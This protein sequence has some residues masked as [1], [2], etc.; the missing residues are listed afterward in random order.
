MIKNERQ[1]RIT[2]AQADQ[3]RR[4]IGEITASTQSDKVESILRKA[5]L[6]G[7]RSQ[8][9]DLEREINEY[10]RLR[11]GRV[12][13]VKVDSFE[14]VPS[15]LVRARIS[16]GLTQEQLAERL[17]L[18][19]QQIQRYE[20][21]E[22]QSASLARLSEIA[23][24]LSVRVR[25]DILSPE[26][27]SSVAAL[28][29]RLAEIGLQKEFVMRRLLPPGT[30]VGGAEDLKATQVPVEA[31]EAVRRVYGWSPATLLGGEP[32]RISQRAMAQG[33]FKLPAR[34]RKGGMAAYLVYAH[35]LALLVL[36]CTSDL[37][38]K[39]LPTDPEEF[40]SGVLRA[41]GEL[42]F[43]G[44]VKYIWSLGVPILPLNDPGSF[45]G[46]CW[47]VKGR[48]I[49]VLRQRTRS[50][51][52]WL[53]DLLHEYFHAARDQN[54]EEHPI[55][56]GHELSVARRQSPEEKDA[57]YF[58]GEVMLGGRAEELAEK[59]VEV[60]RGSVERLKAAVQEVAQKTNVSVGALANYMAFRLSLQGINWWGAATNLQDHWEEIVCTPRDLLLTRLRLGH[61][62]P[63]DRDL[64]LRALEPI[65]LAFSG[66][67]GSGKSTLAREVAHALGWPRASFGDYLREVAKSQGLEESREVLQE[68][69][70]RL[71]EKDPEEFCQAVL[72]YCGWQSGEPLVIEGIRHTSI[73]EALGRLVAP[74]PVRLVFIDVSDEVR[75]KRLEKSEGSVQGRVKMLESHSTEKDVVERLP[76]L[77]VRHVEGHRPVGD[78]V[79]ELVGWIHQ[80]DGVNPRCFEEVN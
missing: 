42:S 76:S 51:A 22:Y 60:A 54:L 9:S 80:G 34:V 58:A 3:F 25:K 78:I 64:I 70:V 23:R 27:D 33:R 38:V 74:L 1:F 67:M 12:S 43:E 65:V 50:A 18:K 63:I 19:A 16:A 57:S 44:V 47:R 29:D 77:A 75:L 7:L 61:L 55:I 52:R 24:V 32:L 13:T 14:D 73:V 40:S 20:A 5:E 46:A 56:E 71:V 35:Y 2:K 21:T 69:G 36:E 59:C 28:V 6:E 45:Y 8:L 11:S 39:E 68:L 30:W 62:N 41:Y 53:H 4:A 17:K 15:A 66:K 26:A 72:T 31:A 37:E 48:N 49:I 79:R 10:E